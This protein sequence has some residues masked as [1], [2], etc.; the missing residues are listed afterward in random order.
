MADLPPPPDFYI[1]A[2]G[3]S[4]STMLSNWL[5]DLPNRIVFNEPFFCRPMNSRLLRIQ[6]SSLGMPV[7]DS[8]WA[9]RDETAQ[10]RFQRLMGPRL[11]GRSWAAKEVL[12]EEHRAM[13]EAF[14]PPK[15]L[16]SVRNIVDVALSF[17]EKHRL[18]DNLDRF[19]D[20]W[21]VEHCLRES[22]GIV[23]YIA[24]L[25]SG[26]IPYLVVRYEDLVASAQMRSKVTD[27]T[28]WPGGGDASAN[29]NAFGRGFEADRHGQSISPMRSQ[30][31]RNLSISLQNLASEIGERCARYQTVFGYR[32]G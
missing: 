29:L 16:V 9:E 20:D 12:C 10:Q 1:A 14:A 31:S 3:R 17:F 26:D 5:S 32:P 21:V 22:A 4:G 18:Q 28:G 6:L 11:A 23:D 2:I 30:G 15:V 7:S 8:E 25:E 27:F 19:G 13:T 24:S